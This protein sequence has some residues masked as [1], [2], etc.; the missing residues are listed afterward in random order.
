[1]SAGVPVNFRMR[2]LAGIGQAI[3]APQGAETRSGSVYESAVRN[4]HVPL[5]TMLDCNRSAPRY[6]NRTRKP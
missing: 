4:A 5:Q 6:E 1:M 3:E 2:K